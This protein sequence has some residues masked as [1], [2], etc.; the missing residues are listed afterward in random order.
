MTFLAGDRFCHRFE[1]VTVK[2]SN[3][4]AMLSTVQM[5]RIRI[6]RVLVANGLV[7]MP[8]GM[9][10]RYRNVMMVLVVNVAKR[11]LQGFVPMLMLPYDPA[12]EQVMLFGDDVHVGNLPNKAK[13]DFFAD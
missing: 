9:R 2:Q 4:S 12:R 10:L 8:V 3:R 6:M 7:P 11:V 1:A 5:M 13:L